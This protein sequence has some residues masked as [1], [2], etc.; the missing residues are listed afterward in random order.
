M[1]DLNDTKKN[2]KDHQLPCYFIELDMTRDFNQKADRET[3]KI[4]KLD[5]DGLDTRHIVNKQ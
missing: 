3:S 2:N 5:F 4:Y 1:S